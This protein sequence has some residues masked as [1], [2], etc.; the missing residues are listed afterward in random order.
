MTEDG[1]DDRK[2]AIE[3]QDHEF[4]KVL[5]AK[6]KARVKR[7]REKARQRKIERER[8]RQE[9]DDPDAISS[10]PE[11]QPRPSTSTSHH[12]DTDGDKSMS[13]RSLKSPEIQPPSRKPYVHEG[14]ID[15]HVNDSYCT[16][17]ITPAHSESEES[18]PR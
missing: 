12:R 15:S 9:N 14:A 18:E 11:D 2:L 10:V 1:N 6:E 17:Q 4:A 8:M 13:P 7:A 3:A 16:R 5:Q